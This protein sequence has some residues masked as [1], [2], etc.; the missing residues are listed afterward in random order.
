MCVV[1]CRACCELCWLCVCEGRGGRGGRGGTHAWKP[2]S[3]WML[4]HKALMKPGSRYNMSYRDHWRWSGRSGSSPLERLCSR[5]AS[6]YPSIFPLSH[7]HFIS[8][9]RAET[10]LAWWA[11]NDM[12]NERGRTESVRSDSK[13]V[14]DLRKACEM[15]AANQTRCKVQCI[16]WEVHLSLQVVVRAIKFATMRMA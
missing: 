5:T 9:P 14:F 3:V 6:R 8:C 15:R 7:A 2:R 13:A 10:P 1:M 4:L 12:E 16:H 11:G